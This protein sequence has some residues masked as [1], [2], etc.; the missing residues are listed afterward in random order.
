MDM[1]RIKT[2]IDLMREHELSE[3]AIEEQDFKLTLKR[4]VSGGMGMAAPM[5]MTWS[6]T[7]RSSGPT[8]T[9]FMA[10][11]GFSSGWRRQGP[12]KRFTNLEV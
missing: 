1:D 3:F 8:H 6:P 11:L 9:S 5:P 7:T 4:G 12:K 10:V 2:V